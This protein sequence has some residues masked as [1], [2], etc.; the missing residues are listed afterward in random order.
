MAAY[1]VDTDI[2]IDV[3]RRR[4]NRREHLYELAAGGSSFACS[5]ITLA[6]LYAGVHLAQRGATEQLLEQLEIFDVTPTIARLGGALRAD[7]S[8]RG[9]TLSLS[10]TLIAATAQHHKLELL[11]GNRKDFP[12]LFPTAHPSET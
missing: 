2:L 8:Q 4:N 5:V 6:E 12:M 3:L 11:T 9:R 10:D 7:W 1:L